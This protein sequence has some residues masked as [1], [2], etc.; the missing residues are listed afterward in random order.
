MKSNKSKGKKRR[1]ILDLMR[2]SS[3]Q[4]DLAWLKEALQNAV[5]LELATLPPYL[6][7]AW[8]ISAGSG[9][10]Y[11]LIMS[12]VMDEMSHMGLACN[13]LT[14]IGGSPAIN[15]HVPVYPGG[16]P[17]G[18]RPELTVY[19]GGLTKDIVG[20][21]FMQIEY[22]ESGPVALFMAETY[23]T[24]GA[25]YTAINDAFHSINPTFEDRFQVSSGVGESGVFPIKNLDDVDKA[26][27]EIK[28]QG[29][30]TS[31]SPYDMDGNLAHYYKFGE[32]YHGKRLI[33]KDG[34]YVYEGADVPFPTTLPMAIVPE[35]GYPDEVTGGFD[36]AYSKMLDLLHDTWNVDISNLG[37]A[38]GAM[39]GL[40]GPAITLMKT[41][42]PNGAGN[43][44]PDWRYIAQPSTLTAN[45][46]AVSCDNPTWNDPIKGFFTQTDINHM[47][48]WMDLA[49][50]EST[51][52]NGEGIYARLEQ[53]NM[54]PGGWPADKIACFK[55]W[56]DNGYPEGKA[57]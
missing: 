50:Y 44:G 52:A 57:T 6:T 18:V 38:I 21:V 56:M 33:E 55:K 23:P 11:D 47:A 19:L 42:I 28:E 49:S 48:P 25:F 32:I 54:P 24:I 26:I 4:H 36:A 14:A 1:N 10:A 9:E 35:G 27:E 43:Y 29:E 22:P 41:P 5:E 20:N 40:Q 17:G 8:S 16:L 13:M 3:D 53:G 15:D 7:G 12:V 39:Y 51:K 45:T 37:S 30:G 46:S 31:Q 2:V 34:K